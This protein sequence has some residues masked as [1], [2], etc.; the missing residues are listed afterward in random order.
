MAK[1]YGGGRG[2][3]EDDGQGA[4]AALLRGGP[5]EFNALLGGNR[6]SDGDYTRLEAHGF[7]WTATEDDIDSA[8]FYNFALGA[9]LLNRH[10]DGEKSM[11]VSVRCIKI[12]E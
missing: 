3:S 11:A 9:Q 2:D 6:D 4:Y 12:P 10:S 1:A 7:Y 8:W 5:S